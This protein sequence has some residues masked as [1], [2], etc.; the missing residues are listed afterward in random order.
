MS[1]PEDD[2][3]LVGEIRG[4]ARLTDAA[5]VIVSVST[6]EDWLEKA[7]KSR[8][9]PLT[10]EV[11]HRLF[12]GYGPLNSFA[13]KIDIAYALGFFERDTYNDLRALKDIRNAF[14]HT[15]DFIFFDSAS[16]TPLFQR[17]TGW[18]K[19]SD[20]K[21]LFKE[22]TNAC[23]EP[24]KKI[25]G[26]AALLKALREYKPVSN[27]TDGRKTIIGSVADEPTTSTEKSE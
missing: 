22:R 24:F 1:E 13:A 21:I 17:L 23:V 7:L 8:M 10:S 2:F 25:L 20:P 16:L 6:L 14:A 9:R 27:T 11:E 18:T 3:D 4:V 15:S 19:D 26:M 12:T 5:V